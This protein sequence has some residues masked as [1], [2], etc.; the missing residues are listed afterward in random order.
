MSAAPKMADRIDLKLQPQ[1]AKAF[2]VPAN[3]ILY[4]GA[5]GGGKSHLMRVDAIYWCQRVPGLQAYIFRRNYGDLRLN[6]MEGPTSFRELLAPLVNAGRC[7]IVEEEI[8]FDNGSKIH[9]CHLQYTKSLQKYQ[10]AEIHW[11]G[12]DEL[13][14]FE[15]KQYR[16][17]RGRVRL[18]SLKVPPDLRHRLPRIVCGTNPGGVG[19]NWVK[20]CFIKLGA[21]R[22]VQMPKKE[23]GLRRVFIPARLE[24]NPAMIANDPDYESRLEGLGDALLVRAMREGDWD[25]V[26]GAMFGDK[27]RKSRHVCD[28]FPIP[29]D[30]K[31]WRGADDGYGAPAAC[32]WLAEQPTTGTI[33]VV[34]ELYRADMLP[35]DYASRVLAK[36]TA[37]ERDENGDV[38]MNTETLDGL[39]DSAAFANNGQSD[40]PRG[41]Q[42]VKA[43]AKFR[44]VEKWPGSRVHRCQDFHRRLA[45]NPKDPEGKPGII[46]FSRCRK[47]I[48]T[49]PTLPRDPNNLED[50][51]TD[52]DDHAYDAVTY[53]LQWKQAGVT[54]RRLGGV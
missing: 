5:A 7:A 36:D 10:G 44:P 2:T 49:I 18:G 29:V 54:R 45:P 14:H 50:V 26:A 52:G 32:Y 30:W 35:H 20:R 24:D 13:T 8:R 53:G 51:D 46:F 15:E 6:H 21:M 12:I 34:D 9:L 39:M 16:Y 40:L 43:G 3:E 19:H 33:Y 48:D 42:I 11:L 41:K 31:V 38:V 47:A 23:G 17:L 28:P 25:V 37:L 1:Q 22:V 27:W 4:G